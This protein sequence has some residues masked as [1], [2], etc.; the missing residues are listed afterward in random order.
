MALLL[1]LLFKAPFFHTLNIIGIFASYVSH[2]SVIII[3]LFHSFSRV[4]AACRMCATP[5]VVVLVDV[6]DSVVVVA[7]LES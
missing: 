3:A 1:T 6:V 4:I 5:V 7:S 2:F